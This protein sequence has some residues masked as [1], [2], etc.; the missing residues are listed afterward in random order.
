[1]SGAD[2]LV[3]LD[4]TATLESRDTTVE[5]PIAAPGAVVD[6]TGAGDA[7]CAGVVY[8]LQRGLALDQVGRIGA[9]AATYVI[10]SYGTQAH[11]YTHDEFAAR[12]TESFGEQIEL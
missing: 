4:I 6:P 11:Q 12:Y 5:I 1:M 2:E 8:G 9:L 7:Y 3:F 10:E